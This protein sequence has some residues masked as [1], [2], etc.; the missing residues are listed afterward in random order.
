MYINVKKEKKTLQN[1]KLIG[2]EKKILLSHN[3]QNTKRTGERILKAAG[4]KGQV[5]YK[6]RP[7][8]ITPDFLQRL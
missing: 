4:E 3:N 5:T 1:T 6:G 2:Q 7:I 8:R